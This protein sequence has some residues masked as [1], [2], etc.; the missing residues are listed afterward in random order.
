MPWFII[1]QYGE[2]KEAFRSEGE[3]KK[4]LQDDYKV[5]SARFIPS[6]RLQAKRI[7]SGMSQGELASKTQVPLNTLRKWEQGSKSINKAA[8]EDVLRIVKALGC[9]IEDILE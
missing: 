4:A 7:A 6:T 8:V 9:Q 5:G 1:G 2:K 3:A